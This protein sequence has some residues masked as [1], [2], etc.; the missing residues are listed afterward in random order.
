M[1]SSARSQVSFGKKFM[2]G[3]LVYQKRPGD[4]TSFFA[5]PF[6]FVEDTL[7]LPAGD[8][9]EEAVGSVLPADKLKLGCVV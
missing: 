9:L 6:R 5:R 2:K 3:K 1:L 8:A 7:I 4:D